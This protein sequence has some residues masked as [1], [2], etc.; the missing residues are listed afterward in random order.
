MNGATS[1]EVESQSG[2]NGRSSAAT[3]GGI[4][5]RILRRLRSK[6]K[7]RQDIRLPGMNE[8]IVLE[9][10]GQELACRVV[11]LSRNGVCVIGPAGIEFGENMRVCRIELQGE[12][13]V[14]DIPCQVRWANSDEDEVQIGLEFEEGTRATWSKEFQNWYHPAYVSFLRGLVADSGSVF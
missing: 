13:L 1:K 4:V 12:P 7:T 2:K 11:N 8:E 6:E 5:R 9:A 3:D 10:D 14:Q